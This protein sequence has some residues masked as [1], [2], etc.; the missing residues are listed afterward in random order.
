MGFRLSGPAVMASAMPGDAFVAPAISRTSTTRFTGSR[1]RSI[2]ACRPSSSSTF[3]YKYPNGGNT[4][5]NVQPLA[6][7]VRLLSQAHDYWIKWVG[8]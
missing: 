1:H 8:I 5:W 2:E 3:T 4:A 6:R 7:H